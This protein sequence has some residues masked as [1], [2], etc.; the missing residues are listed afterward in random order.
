M[1]SGAPA[2]CG[3]EAF[4]R[5]TAERLG[6]RSATCVLGLDRTGLKRML[7]EADSL[8]LNFPVVAWKKKLAEPVLAA[9]TARMMGKGVVVVLHEW[10]DLDWK[11]RLAL[12]PVCLLATAILFSAPEVAAQFAASPI[13][14]AATGRRGLIPI[15]PNVIPSARAARSTISDAL[16][17]QRRMGR[18]ILGQFGSIYP[19]KHSARVLDIAVRLIEAGRDVAVVFVGSF[20]KGQ[21]TVEAD[22]YRRAEKL[23]LRDRVMVTGYIDDAETLSG[24]F[25]EIDA[26]AYAF[27]DGLTERR[28]SV[29]TAA[30][31]GKPVIVNAPRSH[32]GL[33]RHPLFA[34]LV[35]DRLI[36]LAPTDADP[37]ALAYLVLDSLAARRRPRLQ[38]QAAI[39]ELWR[40]I[41]SV[42][43]Q[44]ACTGVPQSGAILSDV[45]LATGQQA[46]TD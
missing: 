30:L 3:V 22:L 4:T 1:V 24:I 32:E 7:R 27:P 6:P 20:I 43:D 44:A 40:T 37:V 18:L 26:F 21:D 33:D 29:L 10:S 28:A 23:G 15:P 11:R 16:R 19:K 36:R 38:P 9:L 35:V 42:V 12:S 17:A 5:L 25:A 14:R 34:G 39:A 8:I 31:S 46:D 45:P 13:A 41:V 2:T